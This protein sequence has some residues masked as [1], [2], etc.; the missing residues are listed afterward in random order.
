MQSLEFPVP[1]VAGER[2]L[3]R[4][5]VIDPATGLVKRIPEAGRQPVDVRA[6]PLLDLTLVP[7]VFDNT[8]SSFAESVVNLVNATRPTPP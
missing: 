6:A 2:A 5:F 1:L 4:V 3:L 7:L 8:E